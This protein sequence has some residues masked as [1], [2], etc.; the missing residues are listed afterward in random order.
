M[1]GAFSCPGQ[2][3][4]FLK[5][6]DLSEVVC[7]KC[8]ARAEFW[9]DDSHRDCRKCGQRIRNPKMDIGCAKWCKFAEDCLGPDVVAKL[10]DSR[11][12]SDKP[13]SS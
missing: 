4:R 10:A 8:G 12:N 9:K 13:T 11:K 1:P 6:E 2:D 7:P 3:N 5:P